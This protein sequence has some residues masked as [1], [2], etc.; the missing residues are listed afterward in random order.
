MTRVRL[1]V[2]LVATAL[3]ASTAMACSGSAKKTVLLETAASSGPDAFAT[4]IKYAAVSS[5][6]PATVVPA[7]AAAGVTKHVSGTAPGLYGGTQN[8]AACD[9]EQMV[10]FLGANPAKAAAW[11]QVQGIGVAQIPAYLRALTPVVL[12][13]DTRVT[14]HGFAGGKATAHQS[15]LQAGTAVL[16]DSAGVP[17]ARCAC[18]NPLLPAVSASGASFSGTAWSSFKPA[19]V[20]IVNA[21]T[22]INHF[23]LVD[24]STGNQFIRP[25]GG[26]GSSDM[27]ATGTSPSLADLPTA[28]DVAPAD[29][30]GTYEFDLGSQY[31]PLVLRVADTNMLVGSYVF[32]QGTLICT[33]SL[34]ACVGWWTQAT[35]D[36]AQNDAGEMTFRFVHDRGA[37]AAEGSYRYGT[38]GAFV[39]EWNLHKS[40]RSAPADVIA[41]FNDPSAFKTGPGS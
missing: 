27:A 2:A 37:I 23:T 5:T 18:G 36:P 39:H 21:G 12:R 28:T 29:V 9:I 6:V 14:N 33:F 32:K 11:A 25:V 26:N 16:V 19:N 7:T 35:R 30:I 10:S 38:S 15:V 22:T 4:S 8:Q 3:L 24:V 40:T 20:V 41:R 1:C 31:G 13:E 34:G 17:R